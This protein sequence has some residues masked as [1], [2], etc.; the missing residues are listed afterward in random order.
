MRFC[1]EA[2]NYCNPNLPLGYITNYQCT[3]LVCSQ[4]VQ[5][6]GPRYQVQLGRR[7]GMVSQAS[8]ASILPGPNV[9]IPTAISLF[10]KKNLNSFDMAILMGTL[11]PTLRCHF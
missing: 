7:D 9:D 3:N 5:C 1:Q 10:S 4:Q 2:D 11:P 6:G 8:R